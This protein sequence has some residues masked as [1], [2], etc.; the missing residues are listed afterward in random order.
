MKEVIFSKI[1]SIFLF[2]VFV[3]L[4]SCAEVSDS[5]TLD[6]KKL[7]EILNS[8]KVDS[9]CTTSKYSRKQWRH[10]TKAERGGYDTRQKVLIEESLIVPMV[11][12]GSKKV[13]KGRWYGAYT[14]KPFKDPKHL[15]IDHLV[16][17]DEAHK[18]GG[19]H[20]DK[21]KKK[22]YANYLKHKEELIAVS[23]KANRAKGQ[24]DPAKWLPKNED[25]LCE[26][27]S[28]WL[29]VKERWNLWIDEKEKKAIA[30]VIE[31][32]CENP[33]VEYAFAKQPQK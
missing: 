13:V 1:K 27:V 8:L 11:K 25:Y 14:D 2:S 15:D 7:L 18:S 30:G 31:N 6:S 3:F 12:S 26:Y 4:F 17:L 10:W 33:E 22:N 9:D 5:K 21:E 23:G 28:D 19:C 29:T 16:P 24:K 20:W 32:Y